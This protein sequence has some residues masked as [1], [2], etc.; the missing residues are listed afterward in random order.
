MSCNVQEL[1]SSG[2]CFAALSPGLRGAAFLA[3]WCDVAEG[4]SNISTDNPVLQ[5]IDDSLWYRVNG[6]EISPG[7]AVATVNQVATDPGANPHL[8]LEN[9]TDGLF[10]EVR[11]VLT[12]PLVQLEIDPTPT[13]DPEIPGTITVGA[14]QYE[15]KIV[16]DPF[17][18]ITLV[19]IP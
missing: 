18:T 12:P 5:S 2:K 19:L 14:D 9:L 17:P 7:N 8:V 4:L 6:I 11:L 16:N 3:L 15:M 13:G 10:Y 1:L